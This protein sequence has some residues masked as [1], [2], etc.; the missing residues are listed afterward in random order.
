MKVEQIKRICKSFGY[1]SSFVVNYFLTKK[2]TEVP[3]VTQVS[4]LRKKHWE[5]FMKNYITPK[6]GASLDD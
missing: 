6:Y 2:D 4:G 1:N 3:V 5:Y